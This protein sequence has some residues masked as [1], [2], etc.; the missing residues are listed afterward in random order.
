MKKFLSADFWLVYNFDDPNLRYKKFLSRGRPSFKRLIESILLYDNIVLPTQD[1]LTL[2]VLIGVLGEDEVIELLRSK[3]IS[4]LR[5]KGSLAYMGNGGGIQSYLIGGPKEPLEPFCAPIDEAIDWALKGL[6]VKPKNKKLP[7]LVAEAT[8]EF[9]LSKVANQIKHE[10]YLDILGS[11]ELRNYFAIRNTELDK[12]AGVKPNGVR[13]FGG[14]DS[15]WQGDEIDIVMA[16]TST[17]LELRMM[18]MTNSD[19]GITDNPIRML[20]EAKAQRTLQRSSDVAFTELKEISELPDIGEVVLNKQV[21][22]HKILEISKSNDA[23]KFREWFHENCRKDTVTS[24]KEYSNLLKQVPL[25]QKLPSRIIRFIVTNIAG[26]VNPT[27]G[28]GAGL[29][30]SFFID[31]L[32]QGSSPK[33]FI[34]KLEQLSS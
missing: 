9:E 22:L 34:E 19:D 14:R 15:N 23:S 2:T 29:V 6:E 10:T 1:F 28:I 30:D 12:L 31:K 26:V 33:F 11:A 7:Q 24:A 3:A 5:T 4:F 32:L 16:L 17:N 27:A 21:P 8:T 13:I 25:V 20:L 18:E